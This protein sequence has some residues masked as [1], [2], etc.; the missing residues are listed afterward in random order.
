MWLGGPKMLPLDVIIGFHSLHSLHSDCSFSSLLF[1]L[2]FRFLSC[3]LALWRRT[4]AAILHQNTIAG[5]VGAAISGLICIGGRGAF[6]HIDGRFAWRN[7]LSTQIFWKITLISAGWLAASARKHCK[8]DKTCHSWLWS[9]IV[10]KRQA[11]SGGSALA[12]PWQCHCY[13]LLRDRSL[14]CRGSV[15]LAAW[16]LRSDG[17]ST[18]LLPQSLGTRLDYESFTTFISACFQNCSNTIILHHPSSFIILHFL[19]SF[20]KDGLR[21]LL[22]YKYGWDISVALMDSL[23][24]PATADLKTRQAKQWEQDAASASQTLDLKLT[25]SRLAVSKPFSLKWW[26]Q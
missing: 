21:G 17:N 9:R 5:Q 26:F 18:V 13:D 15:A 7:P 25:H 22:N 2:S 12:V 14:G 6:F 3:T 23:T 11:K 16:W 20:V 10:I 24:I 8:H 4:L 19:S 1:L